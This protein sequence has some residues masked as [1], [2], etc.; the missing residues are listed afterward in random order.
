M[1]LQV[2][3]IE[4]DFETDEGSPSIDYQSEIIH[5]TLGEIYEIDMSDYENPNDDDIAYE[6]MEE[7]TYQTGWCIKSI[8]YD[9]I[10]N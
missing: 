5:E 7:V 9:Y 3:E 2:T 4:F 6:L 1:K 10:Q 8:D